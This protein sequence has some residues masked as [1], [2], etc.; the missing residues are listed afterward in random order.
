MIKGACTICHWL[1]NHNKLHTMMRQAIGGEA[2]LY[3]IIW[4][5][6]TVHMW[7][8]QTNYVTYMNLIFSYM[9]NSAPFLAVEVD[10]THTTHDTDNDLPSSQMITMT[11]SPR[12]QCR[13][14]GRHHH[15][16]L[17]QSTSSIQSGSESSYYAHGYPEYLAP[18]LSTVV[19]DVQWVYKWDSP[20]FYSML[21]SEW[22]TT[23]AW[24]RQI[25]DD[26]KT[27][28]MANQYIVLTSV[29]DYHMTHYIWM[30][31]QWVLC[32][33]SLCSRVMVFI[34]TTS[35]LCVMYNV[36]CL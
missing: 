35:S 24:T 34:Y 18:D 12:W 19:H 31:H 15:L 26:Y 7:E 33:L 36:K 30:M 28:L 21:V 16:S 17:R 9:T 23:A 22:Q 8:T 11:W 1:Y 13:G 27:S 29:N 6:Y 25:W 4:W 2:I 3:W 20:E 10:F 32:N 14:G 5:C